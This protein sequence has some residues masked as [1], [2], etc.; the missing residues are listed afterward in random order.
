MCYLVSTNKYKNYDRNLEIY[1]NLSFF[2]FLQ[3]ELTTAKQQIQLL[4][5]SKPDG[6]TTTSPRKK[7][8]GMSSCILIYCLTEK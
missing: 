5:K 1:V 3:K 4:E 8:S 2:L 6:N 7:K